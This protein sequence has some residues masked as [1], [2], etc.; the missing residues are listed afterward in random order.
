MSGRAVAAETVISE[1]GS[2]GLGWGDG[3]EGAGVAVFSGDGVVVPFFV[4]SGVAGFSDGIAVAT[5][6]AGVAGPVF[7]PVGE[8]EFSGAESGGVSSL[9]AS[10]RASEW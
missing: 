3:D 10:K 4:E 1:S 7:V 2:P 5:S 6:G 8:A 9:P